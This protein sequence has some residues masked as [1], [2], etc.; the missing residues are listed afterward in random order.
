MPI[1][2]NKLG[3]DAE[4]TG[5]EIGPDGIIVGDISYLPGMFD[6]GFKPDPR[7]GN[8]N[9]PDNYISFENLNLGQE[10]TI[11]FWFQPDWVNG[12]HIRHILAYGKPDRTCLINLH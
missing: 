8:P 7:T 9:I 6:D 4:V 2:W 3:S 12:G 10:G 5:S 11:E 1:L